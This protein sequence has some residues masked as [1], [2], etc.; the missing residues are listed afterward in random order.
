VAVTVQNKITGKT[1]FIFVQ[2]DALYGYSDL[3]AF[4][5]ECC[6]LHWHW[7]SSISVLSDYGQGDRGLIPCRAKRIFPLV[8]VSRPA[9]RLTQLLDQWVPEVLSLGLKRGW[10]VM[11]TTDSHLVSRSRMS[12]SYTASPRKHVSGE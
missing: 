12:R 8:S 5:H 2:S 1:E 3:V 10:G 4:I 7:G 6:V 11:L 9:V